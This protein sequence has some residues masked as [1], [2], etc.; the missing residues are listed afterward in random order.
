MKLL[1]INTT[2]NSGSTGRIAEDIGLA[3]KE[4]GYKSFIAAAYT[5]QSSQSEV[6]TIG[7][8]F[9][10]KLHGLKTRL[11]DRHGF[12]SESATRR[13]TE[14]I[15]EIQPDI[16]H[17][18]NIHGYYLHIGILF[19]YLKEIQIPVVWTF[20]DCWPFTGHCSH[21]ERVN[22]YKWQEQCFKCPLTNGYPAS[23]GVDNSRRN[24]I[25]KR[26]IFNGLERLHI[27]TP[28]QWL[29]DHVKNSFLNNYPVHLIYNGIDLESFSP[30][31]TDEIRRKYNLGV[32]NILLGVASTWKKR[33][34][35][36]DFIQLSQLL[37][38]DEKIVLVGMT[39][40][41]ISNLPSKILGIERTES[42]DELASLYSAAS[43]FINPTYA[44]NFPSSNI[45]ALACGTPVI[46]Y[47]TGG[48]PEAIDKETGFVIERGDIP[49][50]YSAIKQVIAK[51]K[52]HYQPL[53]RERAVKYF[54]KKVRF[55]EYLVLYQELLK[56][57]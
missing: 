55:G 13:L 47:K 23:L 11:F 4:I 10:R 16:I 26:K 17:L 52:S 6:I 46:T 32:K 48:S 53:C 35:L 49:G 15:R 3:V 18:H 21:F 38:E 36:E 41:Q 20:H 12:G 7:N 19:E 14:K 56:T 27:V 24:F 5:N 31:N 40:D 1:Q 8:D 51:G 54:D 42:M 25:D 39:P 33:K 57:N 9:D 44:D 50:L 29:A 28:S 45:E 22:C 2:L 37:G 30:R 43:A 34:A